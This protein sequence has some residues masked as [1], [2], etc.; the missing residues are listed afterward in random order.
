MTPKEPTGRKKTMEAFDF[1]AKNIC[2]KV[3][4]VRKDLNLLTSL[5]YNILPGFPARFF[6]RAAIFSL[7]ALGVTQLKTPY[8]VFF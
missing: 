7:N 8:F 1:F 3:L 2:W 6:A 5:R 4:F